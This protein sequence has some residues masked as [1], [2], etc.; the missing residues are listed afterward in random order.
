MPLSALQHV[1]VDH[2]LRLEAM[3]TLLVVLASDAPARQEPFDPDKLMRI[4]NRIAAGIFSVDDWWGLEQMS[5]TSGLNCPTCRSAI[6]EI[7][8]SRVL[9]FRCRPA[10]PSQPRAC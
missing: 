5:T 1:S 2:C 8:D 6:Y 3:A 9:R 7:T 10:T 4:E